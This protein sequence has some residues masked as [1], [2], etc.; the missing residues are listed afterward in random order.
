MPKQILKVNLSK[1]Y[2]KIDESSNNIYIK[3]V[4][5]QLNYSI[6]HGLDYCKAKKYYDLYLK[7]YE[8][9]QID[10]ECRKSISIDEIVELYSKIK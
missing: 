1:D 10:I 7:W 3:Q 5:I 6:A 9:W 8:D 2:K 4:A